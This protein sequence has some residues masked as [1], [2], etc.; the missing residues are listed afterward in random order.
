LNERLKFIK[1]VHISDAK[2]LVKVDILGEI[3]KSSSKLLILFIDDLKQ[4]QES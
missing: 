2:S 1:D 4:L 3:Q